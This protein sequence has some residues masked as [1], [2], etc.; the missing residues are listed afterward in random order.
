MSAAKRA[1]ITDITGQTGGQPSGVGELA[2]AVLQVSP[3]YPNPFNPRTTIDYEMGRAGHLS[4]RIYNARGELV[5]DLV[6]RDVAAGPGRATWDGADGGGRGV[7]SGVY[8][9][10]TRALGTRNL[11]KLTLLR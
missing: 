5:R 9:C 8:F 2:T 1:L 6:N 10:E 3:A 7:A 11:D 4:I